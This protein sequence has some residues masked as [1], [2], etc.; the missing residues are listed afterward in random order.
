MDVMTPPTTMRRSFSAAS[1]VIDRIRRRRAR[2]GMILLYHRIAEGGPDPWGLA[3]SPAQFNEHLSLLRQFGVPMG[4][5]EFLWHRAERH[6][7]A[8]AIV[9]TFD[10]G[11]ADNLTQAKPL[12]NRH[13][14]PATVF[15]TAGMVGRNRAFWWDELEQRLLHPGTL[16]SELTLTVKGA[17][18]RWTLGQTACYRAGDMRH[19]LSWRAWD[20]A[21]PTERHALYQA[22]YALLF[23]LE[24]ATREGIL[25]K[26]TAWAGDPS[27]A[28]HEA[29]RVCTRHELVQLAGDDSIEIGAHAL[30]HVSLG[31]LSPR[32]QW[33]EIWEGKAL[34]E[35]IV[36][37]PVRSFAFPFG[38]TSDYS[39]ETI[40]LVRAAGFTSACTTAGALVWPLH[41]ALELPR[42]TVHARDGKGFAAWMRGIL[43]S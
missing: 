17:V 20:A 19:H 39:R 34:L 35:E 37:R 33:S 16:P 25:D 7:R 30:T 5:Q 28:A 36:G 24:A 41:D 3:V 1:C 31:S 11:F 32:Q 13:K 26:L 42:F 4:L 14:V 43:Q 2:P 27:C 29:H 18:R 15:V 10:D 9:V 6:Q 21:C 22:L 23:P 8:P 12:L 38:R 40:A